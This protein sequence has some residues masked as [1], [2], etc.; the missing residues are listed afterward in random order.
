MLGKHKPA[1][2]PPSEIAGQGR[3]LGT[4]PLHVRGD[5]PFDED[6]IDIASN[7]G[8]GLIE[9]DEHQ[10]IERVLTAPACWDPIGHPDLGYGS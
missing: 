5:K 10:E 1:E 9:V 7:L 2:T 6:N 3:S 4:G 8:I